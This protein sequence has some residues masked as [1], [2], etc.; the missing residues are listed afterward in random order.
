LGFS[1]PGAKTSDILKT[2]E[3]EIASLN[4]NDFFI[5]WVGSN[6]IS[7]N[8]ILDA[9]RS[10]TK[11]FN[12]HMGANIIF[13]QAPHRHDLVST[14]CINKEVIK[15]NRQVMKIIKSYPNIKS[16]EIDLQRN[17]FTRHGQHLNN[18]GKEQVATELAKLIQQYFSKVETDS[19]QI[20]LEEH[21][22][23]ESN[24]VV[25][26]ELRELVGSRN[27]E[28]PL[29]CNTILC[30]NGVGKNKKSLRT[31]KMPIKISNNFF[32]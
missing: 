5:L 29:K 13:I 32:W 24:V 22:L 15:F 27:Q 25:Q 2:A 17:Y 3:N 12:D 6:D 26:N 30:D 31:R 7:K 23:E 21:N 10:F 8:N 18:I 19:I 14:S 11:F 4:S 9:R 16:L 1:K 20:V 28:T